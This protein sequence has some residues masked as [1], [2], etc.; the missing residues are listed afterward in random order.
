M[1]PPPASTGELAVLARRPGRFGG[2]SRVVIAAGG[3]R[4][5]GLWFGGRPALGLRPWVDLDAADPDA[6]PAIARALGPGASIMVGY[7]GDDTERA[8][9]RRVPAAATPLGLA[10]LRAGCRWLKDW[11]FAEGGREGHT[12]L[13]GELPL[14]ATHRRRAERGL[15]TDLE[16]FLA[17]DD[18]T[19]IDHRRAR[20][21]L[22]LI[23]ARPSR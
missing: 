18:G 19:P 6:L 16:A 17:G 13:Q 22:A 10:L 21:A 12:K 5:R 8:L 7:G 2:E 9:R 14:D 4:A 20:E 3:A 1:R 15:R 11:Y 23:L